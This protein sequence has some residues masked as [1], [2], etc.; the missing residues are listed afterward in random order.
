MAKF[1]FL[2]DAIVSVCIEADS[3]NRAEE[4]YGQFCVELNSVEQSKA[5]VLSTWDADVCLQH[6]EPEVIETH[7]K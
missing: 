5:S 7:K 4:L 6:V 3:K 2:C 1:E